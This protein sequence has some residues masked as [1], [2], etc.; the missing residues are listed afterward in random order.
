MLWL[1]YWVCESV[2]LHW[3]KMLH[4]AG[5][6]VENWTWIQSKL[7]GLTFLCVICIINLLHVRVGG[8]N[9]L[10]Q[11]SDM[12]DLKEMEQWDT[13]LSISYDTFCKISFNLYFHKVLCIKL[14]FMLTK[15]TNVCYTVLCMYVIHTR[16][17]WKVWF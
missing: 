11:L 8:G 3:T 6:S 14:Y 17:N 4:T 12:H 5:S 16:L 13:V 2:R 10:L 1:T 9:Y 15:K 7:N